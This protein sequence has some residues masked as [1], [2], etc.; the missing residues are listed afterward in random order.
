MC[1]KD[2]Y[3]FLAGKTAVGSPP[4]VRERLACLTSSLFSLGDHPRMCG[5]DYIELV[6]VG[7]TQGSPPHVRERLNE[8][9]QGMKRSRITPACAGKTHLLQ[10]SQC[11]VQDHPRMCGKDCNDIA[12]RLFGLGSPPHVR[13]R[14]LEGREKSLPMRITPACAGKTLLKHVRVLSM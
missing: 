3:R 13:E 4:H 10:A 9:W 12:K 5:K 14:L 6:A 7:I 2:S 1:G 11:I 8:V